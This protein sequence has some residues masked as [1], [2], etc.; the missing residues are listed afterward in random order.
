MSAARI[1]L[2]NTVFEGSNNAYLLEGDPTTLI[3]TGI[4]VDPGRSDLESGLAARGLGFA[5]VEQVLLT[6][7]HADH[8]GLAGA[9]QAAGGATVRVHEADA[10]IVSGAEPPF[11]ADA[12]AQ[13]RAFGAW[14][15][16]PAARDRLRAHFSEGT[17]GL[18]GAPADVDTLADGDRIR[19]GDRTLEAVHLPG[20]A[21]G[22]TA[23]ATVGGA[24]GRDAARSDAGAGTGTAGQRETGGGDGHGAAD[25][26]DLGANEAFV[27][28]AILPRYTPNVGGAD[29]RVESPLR[30]YV[31]SLVRIV[32]RGWDRAHPGHRDPIADPA[33]RAAAILQHHR[34]RTRRVLG[35][36][37]DG[38]ADAWTVSAALFGDLEGIHVL[39]GPGEA[40][41][42]LDHLERAGVVRREGVDYRLA[43]P[44]AEPDVRA[45]FPE[46]RLYGTVEGETEGR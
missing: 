18:Y 25:G 38:P 34:D 31:D 21:A 1:R 46:T 40:F 7:W 16:P 36:L 28:D 43:D 12:D 24:S 29:V 19:A 5:D 6:H 27:G 44:G 10:P 15:M 37:R 45:L 32:E 35:I 14:G 13:D 4:A 8:A 11:F 42:H 3:D 26:I 39:H 30:Q 17:A 20:H 33:R 9:I 23:F 41:A 22:L 2:G